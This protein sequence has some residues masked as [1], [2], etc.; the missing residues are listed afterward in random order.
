MSNNAFDSFS[1][2]SKS[3]TDTQPESNLELESVSSV[4]DFHSVRSVR[5]ETGKFSPKVS[6][7][8]NILALQR[9][10]GNKATQR[11]IKTPS[12]QRTFKNEK[13]KTLMEKRLDTHQEALT[14]ILQK[15]LLSKDRLLKNSIEWFTTG[16]ISLYAIVK[17][18]D[19]SSRATALGNAGQEAYFGYPDSRL[20]PAPRQT[21]LY[22]GDNQK[23][24]TNITCQALSVAGFNENGTK[25]AIVEP[26]DRSEEAIYQTIRHEVQHSADRHNHNNTS[27]KLKKAQEGYKTEFRAYSLQD[28]GTG[29]NFDQTYLTSSTYN[30]ETWNIR[31]ASQHFNGNWPRKQWEI[32][33]HIYNSGSYKYIKDA[34]DEE[35]SIEDPLK[36]PFQQT[37]VKFTT[38]ES[39]NPT[40][41]IHL[42]DL[43]NHLDSVSHF[44]YEKDK[45]ITDIEAVINKLTQQEA[46][47]VLKSV[48]WQNAR[49]NKYARHHLQTALHSIAKLP[50]PPGIMVDW[51]D[52]IRLRYFMRDLESICREAAIKSAS[53]DITK[54]FETY[55]PEPENKGNG[56]NKGQ[57]TFILQSEAWAKLWPVESEKNKADRLVKSYKAV[58]HN[59]EREPEICSKLYEELYMA[60]ID[61]DEYLA[62]QVKQEVGASSK[63]PQNI[64]PLE[65]LDNL[66]E[67]IKP[68]YH[69]YLPKAKNFEP[70]NKFLKE[71]ESKLK[72]LAVVI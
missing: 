50:P 5:N 10:I 43:Y 38:P 15:G 3:D 55:L 37:V 52:S 4:S 36:R 47:I 25:V 8:S 63:I 7:H 21:T 56:L 49:L 65:A 35:N 62:K 45:E 13:I 19:S 11:L 39:L 70:K 42:E 51:G 67:A 30:L 66:W 32:F 57:A 40:N 27:T 60:A 44:L 22:N 53:K 23:D 20:L 71:V 58:H 16:K 46:T 41:S 17:T 48:D 14:K 9:T 31:G 29:T 69:N 26:A 61:M 59:T 54:L 64:T 6:S 24:K 28:I 2:G 33:S 72:E 1:N 34:W 68:H 18:H 12:I